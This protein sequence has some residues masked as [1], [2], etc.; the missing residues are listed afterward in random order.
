MGP[1][2]STAPWEDRVRFF[3]NIIDQSL[4]NMVEMGEC[5][6]TEHVTC[7]FYEWAMLKMHERIGRTLDLWGGAKPGE[8]LAAAIYALSLNPQHRRAAREYFKNRSK[9]LQHQQF[10]QIIAQRMG[11]CVFSNMSRLVR[12]GLSYAWRHGV[13]G[14]YAADGDSHE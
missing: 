8:D 4:A 11:L 2:P 1:E 7:A 10:N 3:D 6:A 9:E 13:P 14:E 12:P 5:A